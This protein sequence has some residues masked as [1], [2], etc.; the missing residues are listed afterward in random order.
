[1]QEV[2][3][4]PLGH[5][6]VLLPALFIREAEVNAMVDADLDRILGQLREAVIRARVWVSQRVWLK[7]VKVMSSVPKKSSSVRVNAPTTLLA[8]EV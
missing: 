5:V 1:L 7:T 6:P 4:D 2:S 8:P 3:E